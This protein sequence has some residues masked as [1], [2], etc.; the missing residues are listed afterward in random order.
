MWYIERL[1]LEIK[2]KKN[3]YN[4]IISRLARPLR[5]DSFYVFLHGFL[6]ERI[7][8]LIVNLFSNYLEDI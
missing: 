6:L 3:T 5:T 8:I 4:I 2:K 7:L 1:R